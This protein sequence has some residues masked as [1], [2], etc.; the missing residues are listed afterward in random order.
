[1]PAGATEAV[2]LTA[3]DRPPYTGDPPDDP[4]IAAMEISLGRKMGLTTVA[5]GVENEAQREWLSEEGCNLMQGE[6]SP[7]PCRWP[8]RS[9]NP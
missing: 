9:F 6:R 7:A 5:E 8:R 2:V 4:I 3:Y 1:M